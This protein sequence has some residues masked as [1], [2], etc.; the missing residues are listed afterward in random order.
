VSAVPRRAGSGGRRVSRARPPVAGLLALAAA[1]ADERG[2]PR[3]AAAAGRTRYDPL[4]GS[5]WRAA[6][7]TDRS[8]RLAP[9]SVSPPEPRTSRDD[10]ADAP[11]DHLVG[12]RAASLVV[13]GPGDDAAAPSDDGDRAPADH[14]DRPADAFPADAPADAPPP[15]GDVA[16]AVE[17]V[18]RCQDGDPEAFGLLY[19][20][21]AEM[22]HRYLA[23]RVGSPQLAEDLTSETF[24]RALR[25]IGGW[26]WRGRDVG[27]WLV[28]IARN[29]VA[30]HYKSSRYRLEIST[31]DL[32]GLP[33][34]GVTDGPE[35][36]VLAGLDAEAVLQAVRR[37]RP[38][39]QECLSLRFLQGLS[40]AETAEIMG[41]NE[42]AVKALQHRAVKAMA[43]HLPAADLR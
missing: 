6:R 34:A 25:S 9:G 4:D 22:V 31:D 39:Q 5:P 10:G 23:Y 12:D 26:Q 43:R 2:A 16:D 19:D 27:A 42:G 35:T 11:E 38:E 37:L 32:T 21:Y 3:A 20:R 36:A 13:P 41:K 7:A 33:G 29:L 8:G 24:L 1:V 40:V 14:G 17:L 28:T 15:P 30:D 18:R